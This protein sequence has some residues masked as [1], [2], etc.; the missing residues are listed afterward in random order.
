MAG[1]LIMGRVSGFAMKAELNWIEDENAI[2]SPQRPQ[3]PELTVSPPGG[4][5]ARR[6]RRRE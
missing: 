6:A 2:S 4:S 5:N 3:P 1:H